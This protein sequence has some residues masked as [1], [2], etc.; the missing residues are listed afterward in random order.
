M[1]DN[2]NVRTVRLVN[3]GTEPFT[4]SYNKE[5][6]TIPPGSEAHVTWAAATLWFGD[7]RLWDGT[8][9]KDRSEEYRRLTI[10]YG[11]Y[12]EHDTF[13]DSRP[14]I[15]TYL[16]DGT[17]VHM[18]MED[19]DGPAVDVFRRNDAGP[20][21]VPTGVGTGATVNVQD[22]LDALQ[23]RINELQGG[24][25]PESRQALEDLADQGSRG[26]GVPVDG[27]APVDSGNQRP[28]AAPADG[29]GSAKSTSKATSTR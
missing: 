5:T 27:N 4:A 16:L 17:R 22:Q 11:S 18:L 2:F 20:L 13:Q 24:L 25:T 19:P 12:D 15:E 1:S 14:K 28:K 21:G 10:R 9:Q 26:A 7:P 8:I 29:G 3:A 6:V 23:R